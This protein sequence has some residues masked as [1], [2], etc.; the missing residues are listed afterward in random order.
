MPERLKG[1][2]LVRWPG[3]GAGF[4]HVESGAPLKCPDGIV[5]FGGKRQ[6]LYMQC[7]DSQGR[8]SRSQ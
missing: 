7:W 5:S 4:G 6:G 1:Q 3:R 8:N 2:G